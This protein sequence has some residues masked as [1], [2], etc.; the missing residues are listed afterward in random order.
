MKVDKTPVN[1]FIQSI[2]NE[3][4]NLN[5]DSGPLIFRGEA[6][7][8]KEVRSSLLREYDEVLKCH[9][10]DSTDIF[11]SDLANRVI[12]REA[13][14]YFGGGVIR[15]GEFEALAILQHYGGPT[16][17][18]DFS[19]DWRVA[20]YFACEKSEG[21]DGRIIYF[22]RTK[23]KRCYLLEVCEP[24]GHQHDNSGRSV[25]REIEQKSVLVSA[26]SGKF[27]PM[28]DDL[29]LVPGMLKAG[30]LAWL[31][32]QGIHRESV[33][34]DAHGFVSLMQSELWKKINVAECAIKLDQSV[35][36]QEILNEV[37]RKGRRLGIEQ[38]GRAQLLLGQ[39]FELQ[40]K[41][42]EAL[43]AYRVSCRMLLHGETGTAPRLAVSRCLMRLGL[44]ELAH[45]AIEEIETL[46]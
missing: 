23:A 39:A 11:R 45:E 16:S 32:A 1:G 35:V 30:L 41:Y 21:A 5:E 44:D 24:E 40:E 25:G 7:N 18:M 8:H 33:Y 27:A 22:S 37:L 31:R 4:R 12:A 6:K 38:K 20:L 36:A 9:V 17:L 26:K 13:S 3:F 19:R 42:E 46:W 14:P 10:T 29:R 2:R 43:G 34:R 15:H 28:N